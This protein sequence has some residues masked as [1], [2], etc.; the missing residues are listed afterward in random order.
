[1]MWLCEERRPASINRYS[2]T[3]NHP[4][5]TDKTGM[6]INALVHFVYGFS[7]SQIVFAD[8]QG[9]HLLPAL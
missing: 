8:V 6:T 2:G 5:H 4:N 9:E 7:H 3:L 1:M